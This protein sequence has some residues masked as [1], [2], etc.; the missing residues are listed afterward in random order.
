MTSRVDKSKRESCELQL[1]HLETF[2]KA[3]EL[4]SFTR[5]ANAL[6]ITQA[7]VS[8]HVRVLVRHPHRVRL[9]GLDALAADDDG[10]LDLLA[11]HALEGGLELGALGATGR[12]REDGLVMGR[13]DAD[14]GV[15]HAEHLGK[16]GR[17]GGA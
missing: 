5:A 13:G 1:P 11:G 12:M 14:V 8:Q 2:A 10:N 3:A 6:C 15:D 17:G 9:A 16:F 4:A 7:A